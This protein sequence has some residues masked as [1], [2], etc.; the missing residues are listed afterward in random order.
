[1]ASTVKKPLLSLPL[2]VVLTEEGA[3]YF[4]GNNKKLLRFRLADNAEEYGIMLNK[5]SPLSLQRMMLMNYVSKIEISMA[6]FVSKRLD[7]MDLAKLIVYSLL[8]KQFN[9]QILEILLATD[10][11]KKHNRANPSHLFDKKT[12]MNDSVLHSA[13]AGKATIIAE[14]RREILKPINENIIKNTEYS[15]EEKNMYILMAE[16]FLNRLGLFNWYIIILFKN[17]SGFPEMVE[18]IRGLIKKYLEKSKVAE[19][20]ALMIMELA[21][22]SENAN[23]KKTAMKMYPDNDNDM[24]LYDPEIRQK[25]IEELIRNHELVFLSWKIG[26][27]ATAI[28]KQGRLEITLYNKDDEFQEFKENMDQ[29]KSADL[30]KKNLID[31]YRDIPE[32]ENSG[33]DLGLYYI[34]YLD[35]A[36]RNMNIKFDST[37]NQFTSSDLTVITLM[38]NF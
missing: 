9:N 30:N 17:N 12:K 2:K 38:F 14:T 19:F 37:V 34:S 29:K 16:K 7:V 36:C 28:G 31:F 25:I 23:M 8:Y 11:I 32:G 24:L 3:S 13:L 4:I 1:M 18:G 27:G 10:C 20:T 35:D 5:F 21:Q 6:E 33:N 15:A 22:M 26:G